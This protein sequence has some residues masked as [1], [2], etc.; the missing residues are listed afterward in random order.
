MPANRRSVTVWNQR[1]GSFQN[2]KYSSGRFS[3]PQIAYMRHLQEKRILFKAIS[4]DKS[5]V[6]LD[7]GSGAGRWAIEFSKR[8]KKV[9][10]IEPSD[11][12]KILQENIAKCKNIDCVKVDLQSFKSEEKFD[13]IILSG[14]LM[15]IVDDSEC[16]ILLNKISTMLKKDGYFILRESL[17]RRTLCQYGRKKHRYYNQTELNNCS[18]FD[19]SREKKNPQRYTE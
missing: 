12:F 8:V 19:I 17:S 7:I 14:V 1:F 15:Y 11:A 9:Y 10:A 3:D 13:L 16:E 4:I 5:M 18:Y 2:S 6:V